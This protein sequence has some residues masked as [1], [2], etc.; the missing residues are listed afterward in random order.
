VLIL[1]QGNFN[2]IALNQLTVISEQ[3]TVMMVSLVVFEERLKPTTL[4]LFLGC[5]CGEASKSVPQGSY[6]L[7]DSP[8]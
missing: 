3:L 4:L 8:Q 6:K 7:Y 2:R 5:P 1:V